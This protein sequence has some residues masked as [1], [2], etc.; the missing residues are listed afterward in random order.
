L[1]RGRISPLSRPL[2]KALI[3]ENGQPVETLK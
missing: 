3:L 2:R 1:S